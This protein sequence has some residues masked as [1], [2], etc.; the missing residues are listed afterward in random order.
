QTAGVAPGL[1]QARDYLD[2][3]LEIAI[4]RHAKHAAVMADELDNA[5]LGVGKAHDVHRRLWWLRLREG[6]CSGDVFFIMRGIEDPLVRFL[7]TDEFDF[8]FLAVPLHGADTSF[9]Q[10]AA[11]AEP[12]LIPEVDGVVRC[13]DRL[14][15]Q[16][17]SVRPRW[18]RRR[19]RA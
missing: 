6:L 2:L 10:R 19:S 16:S 1:H 14:A 18:R 9:Q 17:F 5:A 15:H 13:D 7:M 11:V 12:S 4:P 8:T 3:L